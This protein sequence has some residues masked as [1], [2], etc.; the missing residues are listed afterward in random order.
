MS[1]QIQ[2]QP[3]DLKAL[4]NSDKMKAQFA[5]ALPKHLTPE[6]FCRVA[7]T[8]LTRTPKLA[9]CTQESFFKCLLDLSALGIEPDGRRAHL[10]PY[11]R[12][13]TLI[14]DYKGIAELVMRSG[15]VSSIHADK[16]CDADFFAFNLG[17]VE[18]HR[19]DFRNERGEAYAYYCIVRFKDGCE[20]HEVMSRREV[21]A[22]RKRSRAS[23]SGPW[24]TDFDEMAKKTVFRRVSKWLPLSPE[25]RD[26][27]AVD[28]D[29]REEFRNVTPRKVENP[30]AKLP[31]PEPEPLDVT[32]DGAEVAQDEMP[33]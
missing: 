16:V 25:I 13:C 23:G 31:E 9:E 8:A 33:I 12:E 10:I 20:K 27:V 7:I 30:F 14:L 28:D 6:R 32:A 17:K 22:V 1:N 11:G 5:A 19:I 4:L 24:V 15:E 3:R 21:E 26:A 29:D 2:Q 18:Q